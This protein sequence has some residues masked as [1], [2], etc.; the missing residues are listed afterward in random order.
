MLAVVET[1][2][3]LLQASHP[4]TQVRGHDIL[5]NERGGERERERERERREGERDTERERERERGRE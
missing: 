3:P 2:A 5:K 1:L 4:G